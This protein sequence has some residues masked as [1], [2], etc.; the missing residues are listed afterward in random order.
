MPLLHRFMSLQPYCPQILEVRIA[1]LP[2][3]TIQCRRNLV[4]N[5]FEPTPSGPT[6]FLPKAQLMQPHPSMWATYMLR[7]PLMHSQ[8][9]HEVQKVR[10]LPPPHLCIAVGDVPGLSDSCFPGASSSGEPRGYAIRD[11]P[12]Y[13][14]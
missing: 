14:G 2:R 6:E 7:S 4:L 8:R 3:P 11:H 9:Y 13:P 12:R 5:S 10:S 1:R